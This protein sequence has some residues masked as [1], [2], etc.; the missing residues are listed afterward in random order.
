[1][2]SQFLLLL[3][4]SHASGQG[5]LAVKYTQ[6]MLSCPSLYVVAIY[7]WLTL[8]LLWVDE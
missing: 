6:F 4:L 5:C 3:A 8:G 1:V 2:S 7:A